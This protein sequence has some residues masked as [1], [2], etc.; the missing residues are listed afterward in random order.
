MNSSPLF[1]PFPLKG[2]TVK[3]RLIVPPMVR[4]MRDNCEGF[5]DEGDVVH[6][7]EFARGGFGAVIVEA[8]CIDPMGRL[9]PRQ[10]GIWDD[11]FLPGLQRL[12]D[13]IH[14]HGA[15]AL[16]QI[17]HAGLLSHT[18]QPLSASPYVCD[19]RGKHFVSREMRAEEIRETTERFASAARR[20][21]RA[22]FDGV[23]IHGCHNYLLSQF[24]SSRINR[25]RDVYG[26]QREKFPL[27]VA[28][29]VKAAVSRDFIVGIRLGA[30]EPSL[31]E[32]LHFAKVFAAAGLDFLNVSY[33]FSLDHSP[34]KPEGYPFAEAIYGAQEIK[35]CVDIPVF[36]VNSITDPTMAED[37]LRLS[38]ADAICIGRGA[39]VNPAWALDAMEG[40]S[41][42][43]CFHCP[44][45]HWRGDLPRC[46]GRV[47]LG[48]Q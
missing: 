10:L 5:V 47:E 24:L 6:Y 36:A 12:S 39:L 22:G 1:S 32:G 44:E 20:A 38:G 15:L 37:A 33:G 42:G 4:Y 13:A 48:S 43:R 14:R 2:K 3:N 8:T 29:A 41:T 46:P 18:Q 31:E 23:E 7:S 21:E 16:L 34:T 25:R 11:T 35:K 9:H 40:R 26:Q 28:Q 19:H 30:F 17:H 27:A 45:C